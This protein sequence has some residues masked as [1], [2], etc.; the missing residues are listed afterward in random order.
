MGPM[1]WRCSCKY[2]WANWCSAGLKEGKQDRNTTLTAGKAIYHIN[3]SSRQAALGRTESQDRIHFLDQWSWMQRWHLVHKARWII[4]L[5]NHL[6]LVGNPGCSHRVLFPWKTGFQRD[7]NNLVVPIQDV[8]WQ[9]TVC[10][11]AWCCPV[12]Y[13]ERESYNTC[14]PGL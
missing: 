10:H 3:A 7:F 11:F 9:P 14:S 2:H 13:L 12:F 4:Q 1:K 6:V 5:V 8:C